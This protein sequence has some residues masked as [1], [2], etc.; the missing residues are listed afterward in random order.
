MPPPL[1]GRLI[2]FLSPYIYLRWLPISANTTWWWLDKPGPENGSGLP[3][4]LTYVVE[5]SLADKGEICKKETVDNLIQFVIAGHDTTAVVPTW[6]VY[7]LAMHVNIQDCLWRKIF[8]V[9]KANS[10]SGY[11]TIE[12]KR[13]LDK[14]C[15]GTLRL[16]PT[17]PSQAREA[18]E[19]MVIASVRI[20]KGTAV[21]VVPS[22]IQRNPLVWGESAEEFD[23]DRWGDLS[24]LASN[25]YAFAA[26]IAGPRVCVGKAFGFLEMKTIVTEV[27]RKFS[28]EAVDRNPK[29]ANPSMTLRS[30]DG[31]RAKVCRIAPDTY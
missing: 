11:G 25:T 12:D 6:L 27:P 4:L 19:D 20:S 3:G 5:A 23:P 16:Y 22:M 14:V 1:V 24:E 18:G 10:E 8:D 30:A 17:S 2:T 13:Y 29:F 28:F 7:S 31:L 15:R 21:T 26:F 9:L